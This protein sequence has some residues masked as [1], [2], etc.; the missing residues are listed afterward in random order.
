[1]FPI[2]VQCWLHI[3]PLK[4]GWGTCGPPTKCGPREHLIWRASEFLL[5]NLEHKIPSWRCPMT[6]RYLDT[7]VCQENPLTSRLDKGWIFRLNN[8]FCG[9]AAIPPYM[10]PVVVNRFPTPA[11]RVRIDYSWPC[12]YVSQKKM[13][14]VRRV[15]MW[16]NL[17]TSYFNFR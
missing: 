16:S 14:Y 11:L 5:P 10:R 4:Q 15:I 8:F 12:C 2:E 1:M 3:F 6:S 7:V 9:P 17:E 13:L